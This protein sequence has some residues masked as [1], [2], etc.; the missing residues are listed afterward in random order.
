MTGMI[1]FVFFC[2]LFSLGWAGEP[3]LLEE[4]HKRADVDCKDCHKESPPEKRVP[5]VV[6]YEC[7]E[8]QNK[9]SE[10]TQKI[11]PNPHRSHVDVLMGDLK[12]EL[13]H[14]VHKS[15]EDYCAKCHDFG[16]NIR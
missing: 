6:C 13:C 14:H 4:R 3:P 12:C 1:L 2:I 11:K 9:L 5:T 16:Y 10:R 7:H 8:N 15:S